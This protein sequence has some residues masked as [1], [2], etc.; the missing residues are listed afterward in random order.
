M[1]NQ[2]ILRFFLN[3]F[4]NFSKIL[5]LKPKIHPHGVIYSIKLISIIPLIFHV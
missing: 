1:L 5:N 3:K 2:Y 4:D